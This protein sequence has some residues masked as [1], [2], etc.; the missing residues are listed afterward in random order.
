MLLVL[1]QMRNLAGQE[2]PTVPHLPPR[3]LFSGRNNNKFPNVLQKAEAGKQA[4]TEEEVNILSL[5]STSSS[6]SNSGNNNKIILILT[7]FSPSAGLCYK[8]GGGVIVVVVS[9]KR[10]LHYIIAHC[11]TES[12]GLV[13]RRMP[14]R[15]HT[16]SPILLS[17]PSCPPSI[18]GCYVV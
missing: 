17:G 2:D 9:A 11:P 14:T 16:I 1:Q 18:R 7:A 8:C 4:G 10:S 5:C 6:S 15:A 13:K 12:H 3:A